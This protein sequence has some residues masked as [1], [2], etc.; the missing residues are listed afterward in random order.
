M[1]KAKSGANGVS[2]SMFP[3]PLLLSGNDLSLDPHY[4]PQSLRLWVS[5]KNCNE[6]TN[7]RKVIY[8]AG[9]PGTA[10]DVGFVCDWEN[11]MTDRIDASVTA[12]APPSYNVANYLEALLHRIQLS[13][14]PAETFLFTRW[15]DERPKFKTKAKSANL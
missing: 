5:K 10:A 13:T 4:P 15:K 12:A 8:V 6:V 2:S 7:T 9:Q 1:G 14:L 3:A 11:A